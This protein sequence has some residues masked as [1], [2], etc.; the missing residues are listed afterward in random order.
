MAITYPTGAYTDL[1]S[2]TGNVSPWD[3]KAWGKGSMA[4]TVMAP[5]QQILG[6]ILNPY[7][8][9][10]DA[11]QFLKAVAISAGADLHDVSI[12]VLDNV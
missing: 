6:G 10:W 5:S 1:F 12:G 11:K 8:T 4:A 2:S 7:G 9:P 3:A